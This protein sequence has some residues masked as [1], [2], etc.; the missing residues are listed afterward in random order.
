MNVTKD[1]ITDLYPLYA[2]KECSADTR[3]LVEEYLQH[4]PQDAAELRRVMNTPLPGVA[5]SAQATE[6]VQALREARRRVR[7]RSWLMALA[8]FF[9]LTPLS[10][11]HTGEKTYWLLLEAPAMAIIYGAL[12]VV[13]WIAY[14]VMGRRS[15]SL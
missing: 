6:E 8:I 15:S 2:E 3:A 13:C 14:A 9:S 10:F 12:G 7:R 4:N 11:L 5:P 1:V